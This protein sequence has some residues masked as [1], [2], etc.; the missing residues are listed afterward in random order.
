MNDVCNKIKEKV[1]GPDLKAFIY[2]EDVM[3]W[4]DIVKKT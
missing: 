3:M 2:T 4:G 1:K